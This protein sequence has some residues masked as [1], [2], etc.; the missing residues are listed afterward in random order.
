M[1]IFGV[2]LALNTKLGG[3]LRA[4]G[5]GLIVII[6]YWLILSICLA[7]GNTGLIYPELAPWIS[8]A[9]FGISGWYMFRRIKE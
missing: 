3:G 5:L 1:I 8:P 9:L 2:A 4:A 7:F 6:G